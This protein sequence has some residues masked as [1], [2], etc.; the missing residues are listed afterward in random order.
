MS[1][2]QGKTGLVTG[3]TGSIGEA[4]AKRFLNEGANVMLVGRSPEKLE[5]TYGPL[6]GGANLAHFVAEA[7]DE[8]ATAGAVSA[9][10]EAFGGFD[11]LV[12]NAGTE[13]QIKPFETQTL[14]EFE[15]VLRTNV[16]GV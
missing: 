14:E 2:L 4:I 3:A 11:I 7:A 15:D 12:A 1:R 8:A 16:V 6:G 10:L 9:T 13:G 5:A